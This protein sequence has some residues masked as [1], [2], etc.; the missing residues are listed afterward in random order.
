MPFQNTSIWE[1]VQ[2]LPCFK[3]QALGVPGGGILKVEETVK[4]TGREPLGQLLE[5]NAPHQ[6]LIQILYCSGQLEEVPLIRLIGNAQKN[7]EEIIFYSAGMK[8]QIGL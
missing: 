1:W 5:N 3:K 7:K 6:V 8:D 4:H 2:V